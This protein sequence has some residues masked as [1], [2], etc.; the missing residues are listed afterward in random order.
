MKPRPG[1]RAPGLGPDPRAQLVGP[2]SNWSP[3]E[4]MK[5]PPWKG[6]PTPLDSPDP[7]SCPRERLELC[8]ES[9]WCPRAK[10][11]GSRGVRGGGVGRAGPRPRTRAP[12]TPQSEREVEG[13]YPQPCDPPRPWIC[14][15]GIQRSQDLPQHIH[16]FARHLR[17]GIES[18]LESGKYR[19]QG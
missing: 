6:L 8:Q 18:V 4:A 13:E 11:P 15:F 5:R 2:A 14:P 16:G 9:H 1:P 17:G 3:G 7:G 19:N 10:G 12:A